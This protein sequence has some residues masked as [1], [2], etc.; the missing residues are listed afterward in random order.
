MENIDKYGG[1]ERWAQQEE[2]RQAGYTNI[3][4]T[5]VIEGKTYQLAG[6]YYFQDANAERLLRKKILGIK[7]PE[8]RVTWDTKQGRQLGS[9]LGAFAVYVL[10][11]YFEEV[12]ANGLFGDQAEVRQNYKNALP[13]VGYG[14]G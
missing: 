8:T 6:V 1:L 5:W 9:I 7:Y 2:K 4:Q 3:R 13:E 14:E 12:L 11:E 10:D